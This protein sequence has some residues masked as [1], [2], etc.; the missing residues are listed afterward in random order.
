MV[1]SVG[2]IFG[3]F[4]LNVISVPKDSPTHPRSA[5]T[6]RQPRMVILPQ[7]A[8]CRLSLGSPGVPAVLEQG[9][10]MWCCWE[11]AWLA[12]SGLTGDGLL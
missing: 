6:P 7:L 3:S 4:V 1:L 9:Q 5:L 2:K 10:R 11:M 12:V 8:P